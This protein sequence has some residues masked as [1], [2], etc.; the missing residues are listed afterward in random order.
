MAE[1]SHIPSF[2]DVCRHVGKLF[3]EQ[4]HRYELLMHEFMVQRAR[5]DKASQERDQALSM[6]APKQE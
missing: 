1:Q 6:L 5:A 3:L 4:Q 2:E